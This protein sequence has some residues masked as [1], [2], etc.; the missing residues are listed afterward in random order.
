[1]YLHRPTLDL[2]AP[3]RPILDLHVTT[4]AYPWTY[5]YMYLH[6]TTLDLH[7]HAPTLH[8]GGGGVPTCTCTQFVPYKTANM[9][10]YPRQPNDHIH[11][12]KCLCKHTQTLYTLLSN[13]TLT[14]TLTLTHTHTKPYSLASQTT[15]SSK[16][17]LPCQGWL[18]MLSMK[19]SFDDG[20][21]PLNH[22]LT[23]GWFASY[24]LMCS[25]ADKSVPSTKWAHI[26]APQSVVRREGTPNHAETKARAT[27]AAVMSFRPT[28]KPIHHSQQVL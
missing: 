25:P 19:R 10:M 12:M 6:R 24:V 27:K 9:Y 13:H 23:E 21:V 5:I 20:N 3:L 22:N 17:L 7:V 2:H 8:G 4:W 18:C 28:H 1:M 14:H 26:A 11:V 16:G 15:C